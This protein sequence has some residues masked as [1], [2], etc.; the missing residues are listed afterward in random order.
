MLV[1]LHNHTLWSDGDSSV[2]ALV[3]AAVGAGVDHL[4]ISDH[5]TLHPEGKTVEWSMPLD[6]LGEY[7]TDVTRFSANA[8]I[9]VLLGLEV[10]YFPA[11]A[12][13]VGAVLSAQPFDYLIGSIHYSTD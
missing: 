6:R 10:D 3:T 5:Y 7:I 9:K 12:S 11:N 13:K 1:S 4:G 2:D 8:E